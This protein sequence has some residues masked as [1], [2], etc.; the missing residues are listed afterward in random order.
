MI[1]FFSTTLY[2][3]NS[4]GI[5]QLNYNNNLL[6]LTAE[7]ADLKNILL[8]LSD[9]AGVYVNYPNNLKKHVTL[10]LSKVSLDRA[11]KKIL[12]G[13]NHAVIY[14]FSKKDQNSEVSRIYIFQ[15]AKSTALSR[16]EQQTANSIKNY[17]KRIESLKERLSNLDENSRRGKSYLRQIKSYEDRIE[18]LKER[19]R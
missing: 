18:K 2:A 10:E 5:I 15:K 14:S 13:I 8:R 4:G 3:Q 1:I 19:L 9:E 12:K 11:I 16:R 17:E 6:T 7:K